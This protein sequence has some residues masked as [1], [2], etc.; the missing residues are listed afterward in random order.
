MCRAGVFDVKDRISIEKMGLDD[1]VTVTGLRVGGGPAMTTLVWMGLT[2]LDILRQLQVYHLAAETQPGEVERLYRRH[3]D[4]VLLALEQPSPEGWARLADLRRKWSAIAR[5]MDEA[6]RDFA[7]LE[8]GHDSF[9]RVFVSGDILTKANDVANGRLYHFMSEKRLRLVI[10][11][12]CDFLEYLARLHPHLLFGK[13]APARQVRM[14]KANMILI[15]RRMY[16]RVRKH[17][18]WLPMPDV[19]GALLRTPELLDPFTMG[20]ASLIVGSVLQQWDTAQYDG[21]ALVACWSCDNGLVAESLLRYRKDIP[22]FFFYDDGTPIDE[23]RVNSF[24]FRLHRTP[25]AAAP[26]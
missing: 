8:S 19:K 10:E 12:L 14:Y 24:A 25:R 4:A 5:V 7:R 13:S 20:G 1:Q 16:S 22:F 9:R 2:A 17:H 11:P 6:S 26:S 3:C 15:R 23:R 21:I 18:P